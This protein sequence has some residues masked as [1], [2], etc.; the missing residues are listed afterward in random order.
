MSP[1]YLFTANCQI[2]AKM[3][4]LDASRMKY[5]KEIERNCDK[6]SVKDRDSK[7]KQKKLHWNEGRGNFVWVHVASCHHYRTEK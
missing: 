1:L 6:D 7:G 5:L 3:P 2:K 4:L